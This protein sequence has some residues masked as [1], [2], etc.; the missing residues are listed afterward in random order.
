MGEQLAVEVLA[1]LHFILLGAHKDKDIVKL[2]QC[3]RKERKCLLT[4]FEQYI[5]Y[6]LARAQS[7]YPNNMHSEPVCYIW[8]KVLGSRSGCRP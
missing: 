6:S 8:P 4:G 1:G 7:R 5:V 2:L 3:V